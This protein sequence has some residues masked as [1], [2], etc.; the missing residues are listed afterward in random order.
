MGGKSR[1]EAREG[2]P[3]TSVFGLRDSGLAGRAGLELRIPSLPRTCHLRPN[4]GVV[5]LSS[6]A[7]L[8]LHCLCDKSRKNVGLDKI[9]VSILLSTARQSGQ[10]GC[11]WHLQ[12]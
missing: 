7:L 3:A 6:A 12:V 5:A 10:G 8:T 9:S 1:G 4:P 2:T 11:V